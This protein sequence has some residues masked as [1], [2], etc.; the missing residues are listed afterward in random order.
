VFWKVIRKSVF[1]PIL[2]IQQ[3]CHHLAN[4]DPSLYDPRYNQRYLVSCMLDSCVFSSGMLSRVYVPELTYG[5]CHHSH[6]VWGLY[7]II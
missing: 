3:H 6:Y 5:K 1:P 4:D 7:M 2:P